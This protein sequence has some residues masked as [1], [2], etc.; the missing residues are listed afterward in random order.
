MKVRFKFK[1]DVRGTATGFNTLSLTEVI[2][3]GDWGVE[4]VPVTD[5]E[6]LLP[7]EKWKDMSQAFAERDIIPNNLNTTF[8]VPKTEKDKIRGYSI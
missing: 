5:L 6:V 2:V 7:N 1:P 8:N 4:S 3:A